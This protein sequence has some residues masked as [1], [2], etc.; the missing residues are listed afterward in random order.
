METKKGLFYCMALMSFMALIFAGGCSTMDPGYNVNIGDG[1]CLKEEPYTITIPY[2]DT[3]YEYVEVCEDKRGPYCKETTYTDFTLTPNYFGKV[4]TLTVMNTGNITGN[5]TLKVQFITTP[6][7]GGPTSE[8]ITKLVK[9][10]QTVKFDYKYE[11]TDIP[12]RCVN[13][14]VDV[15]TQKVC[16]CSFIGKER[17][18]KL[19]TKYSVETRYRNVTV[20]C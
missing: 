17:V 10:G 2:N 14:N 5:W 19:V 12:S 3:E 6:A 18:P 13:V 20:D 11:G 1:K 15:P 7:G 4:C 16:K 9:A 8:S